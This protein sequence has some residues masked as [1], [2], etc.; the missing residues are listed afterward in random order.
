MVMMQM[1]TAGKTTTLRC[2]YSVAVTKYHGQKQLIERKVHLWFRKGR[3]RVHKE[4]DAGQQA[5]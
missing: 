3:E 2:Y 5:V 1:F 4:G